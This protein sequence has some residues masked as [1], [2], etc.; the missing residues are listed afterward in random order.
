MVI[1][2]ILKGRDSCS[3]KVA[4]TKQ[5]FTLGCDTFE[6]PWHTDICIFTKKEEKVCFL[7][8]Y[9]SHNASAKIMV[10]SKIL[11]GWKAILENQIAIGE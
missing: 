10:T 1:C 11:E 2:W 8:D 6:I 5:I 9:N 3:V 4:R 7:V